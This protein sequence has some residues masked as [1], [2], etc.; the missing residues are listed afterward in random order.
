MPYTKPVRFT[1]T[2][3][4]GCGPVDED[5]VYTIAEFRSLCRSL[6]FIDSDG[7]G[8]PVRESM[9]DVNVWVSPSRV[10]EIPADAT[11]VVWYNK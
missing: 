2:G 6:A 1:H 5:D 9:A 4:Y 10:D 3:Q 7:D 11:H 8:H